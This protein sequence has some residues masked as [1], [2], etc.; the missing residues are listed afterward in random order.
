MFQQFRFFVVYTFF[1]YLNIDKDNFRLKK[2]LNNYLFSK[3]LSFFLFVSHASFTD[4]K[5]V[6]SEYSL[7]IFIADSSDNHTTFY[8]RKYITL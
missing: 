5:F 7:M 1:S 8:N 3:K 6:I 4:F 2:I